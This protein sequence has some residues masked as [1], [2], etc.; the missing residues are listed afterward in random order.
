VT[1]I[2]PSTLKFPDIFTTLHA[3]LVSVVVT[4][5]MYILLSVSTVTLPMFTAI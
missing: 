4:H 3:A 5:V 2:I 1:T